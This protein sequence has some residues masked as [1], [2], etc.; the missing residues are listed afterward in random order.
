MAWRARQVISASTHPPPMVPTMRPSGYT[1]ILA[2]AFCGVEPSVEMTVTRAAFSPVR[3]ARSAASKTSFIG[4]RIADGGRQS[5]RRHPLRPLADPLHREAAQEVPEHEA[6]DLGPGRLHVELPQ[7]QRARDEDG[8][9]DEPERGPAATPS[10]F[11]HGS[12]LSQLPPPVRR[13]RASVRRPGALSQGPV[14][15]RGVDVAELREGEADGRLLVPLADGP[16]ARAP[17]QGRE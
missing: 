4:G 17:A 7:P 14:V 9:E 2:P 16:R 15:L 13:A 8:R 10:F 3:A 11:H 12:R 6:A 1:T 5:V